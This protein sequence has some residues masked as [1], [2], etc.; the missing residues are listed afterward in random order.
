M[1][2]KLIVWCIAQNLIWAPLGYAAPANS[3][4]GGK[5]SIDMGETRPV[6][7]GNSSDLNIGDELRGAERGSEYVSGY[8]RGA[9]MIP[10]SLW[11]A[12]EKPGVHHVPMRTD[13]LAFLSLAG[14]PKANANLGKVSIKRQS[15]HG[16]EVLKADLNEL[17]TEPTS[18]SMILEPN[19][20]VNVPYENPIV[21]TNTIVTIGLVAT[22]M[23]VVTSIVTITRK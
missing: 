7:A 21:D 22:I 6:D 17:L 8:Y 2:K 12:V 18:I 1:L 3:P 14:G 19:D 13:L 16:E 4:Y 23:S 10:I 5:N 9:I 15:N 11:G 20:I